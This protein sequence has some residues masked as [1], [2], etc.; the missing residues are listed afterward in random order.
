MHAWNGDR[1]IAL[2]RQV[3]RLDRQGCDVRVLYGKGT[4]RVV[5]RLFEEREP[6]R[7]SGMRGGRR[8]TTR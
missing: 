6:A 4:G 3:V 1:G 8:C 5:K 2:A 7:D